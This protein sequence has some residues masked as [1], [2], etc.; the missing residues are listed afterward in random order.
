[1]PNVCLTVNGQEFDL[2]VEANELLSQTL[3]N[4]MG[5]TGTKVSCNSQVCGACSVIIDTIP[6][7][8]CS[9]L[10]ADADG[11]SVRTIEGLSSADGLH[12]V[13]EA[14]LAEAAFQCG[15]CTPGMIMSAIA[16]L[17]V[18]ADP[19]DDE[20]LDWLDGSICRCTGYRSIVRA[21]RVAATSTAA[22][23]GSRR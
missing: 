13:Q 17:E 18:S 15:F 6:V 5:L 4:R 2:N 22:Q 12:P 9:F 7:S 14:F 16:L 21:I 11:R 3:R 23:R 1:M 19:A 20:I 10:T 8:S